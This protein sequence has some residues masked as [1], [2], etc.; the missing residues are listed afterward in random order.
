MWI[1][2]CT[3]SIG[4]WMQNLAQSWLVLSLSN[5]PFLLGLD[6]FLGG[7]PIFLFSLVGGVIADRMDRRKVLLASQ[8]VQMASAFLLTTLIA[9]H[10]IHVWHI[11]CVSFITGLAQ[12]FGGPAYQALI[13]TLVDKEDMPN[14]I[15][16]QT[17]QFNVARVIGP[18]LGGLA[19]T[20]LGEKWCFGLNGLS[21]LAPVI[22]L[23]IVQPSF[24]PAKTTESI[25]EA[26]KQGFHFV[27]KQGAMEELMVLAFCM[28]ALG[29]PVLTFLP[30]VA[31]QVFRGGPGVFTLFLSASGVGSILG[32]LTVAFFSNLKHKGRAALLMLVC[33]GVSIC[34]FALSRAVWVSCLMLFI[35]G[36]SLIAVFTLVNSLVQL[37]TTNEM[38]GRVMSVYNF[39]FR[40]GMPMG[41]LLAGRL[42]DQFTVA[43]VLAVNGMIL[44]VVALYFLVVHRRVA[45]L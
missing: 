27:R 1:G 31:K 38:R 10:V 5:S 2:A 9:F 41:N 25:L 13:P 36:A 24:Q 28:T 17:I 18:A 32:A 16:L 19:L 21:F 40:G 8:Y 6:A 20:Q 26:M 22:S 11:L 37:I 42:V 23:T 12:A 45:A 33:L 3:S 7:I 29:I 44:M 4:T 30:V 35:S 34:G 39:A 14:A 43:P 15:A